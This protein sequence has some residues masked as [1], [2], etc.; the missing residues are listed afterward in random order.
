MRII[1][2]PFRRILN[3][4]IGALADALLFGGPAAIFTLLGF[5]NM[6]NVAEATEGGALCAAIA[7]F[8]W[9]V[10]RAVKAAVVG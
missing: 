9:L 6:G 5:A 1:L 8:S 7:F 2:R 10:G 4:T 3:L